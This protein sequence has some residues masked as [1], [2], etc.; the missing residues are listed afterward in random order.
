MIASPNTFQAR[1]HRGAEQIGGSCVELAYDGAR[2]LLD[3]GKP[4]D[5]EETSPDLLPKIDG[6]SAAP[7]SGLLAIVISHGHI[8]HWG[9]MPLVEGQVPVAMGAATQRI[10]KAAAPFVPQGYA[11]DD[12]IDLADRR[13][14]QIGPF[15]ITPYL[16][17]HSAY[18][19]YAL[20]I[21]AGG[22]RL[23][24]SGDIRGHGRKAKLFEAMV[25]HQ[26]KAIDSMLMRDP[27][28]AG[29]RRRQSF[30]PKRKSNSVLLRRFRHP[31][32]LPFRRPPRILTAS[33]A[34]TVLARKRSER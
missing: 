14:V 2:I 12:T 21:E 27:A 18:D 4:L 22:K 30:Q 31:A 13:V 5:A 1:I 10:L 34:F 8:D 29:S 17:D 19:A 6:L 24:Y 20:T 32:L 11:P 9:L 26:P 28:S 23:F 7:D 15:S 3:L 25:R 16:V 33:S